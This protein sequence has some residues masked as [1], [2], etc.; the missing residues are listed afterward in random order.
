MHSKDIIISNLTFLNSPSWNLHPV[1]SRYVNISITAYNQKCFM[2]S[3][4]AEGLTIALA[5][6]G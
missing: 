2:L 3:N 4:Y 6:G 1:Y 5:F